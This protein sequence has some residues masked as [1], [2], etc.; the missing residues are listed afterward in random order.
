[1][2]RAVLVLRSLTRDCGRDAGR[3][4]PRE[5]GL[6]CP[7]WL[8]V[9]E[10]LEWR[11]GL[12]GRRRAGRWGWRQEGKRLWWQGTGWDSGCLGEGLLALLIIAI[13]I[14]TNF[15]VPALLPHFLP[16]SHFPP[17]L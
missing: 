3:S 5:A 12:P 17:T 8:G 16:R 6:C 4:P 14:I 7:E 13:V 2:P 9:S 15:I 10:P 11:L 1:M